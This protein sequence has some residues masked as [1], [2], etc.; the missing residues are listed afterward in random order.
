MVAKLITSTTKNYPMLSSRRGRQSNPLN[1]M[2][3][4]TLTV[5]TDKGGTITIYRNADGERHNP[6]GPAVIWPDGGKSYYINDKR[7]NPNGP[8]VVH[9][10]GYKAYYINGKLHNPNGPAIVYADGY[11]A[12]YI[13]GK[14]HNPDGPALIWPDGGKSYWINDKRLTE[15]K[16]KTWQ[17]QQDAPL[18]N[19]TATIDGVEYT[20]TVK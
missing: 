10:D 15:A 5:Y 20:L 2:N 7:H 1:N 6:H 3:K 13:N 19:K 17:A 9:A 12:Y 16:F 14:R 8:A 18:H 4:E 11:K